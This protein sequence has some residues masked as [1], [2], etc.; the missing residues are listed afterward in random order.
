MGI[1]DKIKE[2]IDIGE[3]Y[4]Y[5]DEEFEDAEEELTAKAQTVAVGTPVQIGQILFL[6]NDFCSHMVHLARQYYTH[7]T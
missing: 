6:L 7:S 4:D 5:E 1:V 3:D 2:L